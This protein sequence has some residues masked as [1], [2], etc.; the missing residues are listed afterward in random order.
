MDRVRSESSALS[1]G[2][3]EWLEIRRFGCLR[4]GCVAGVAMMAAPTSGWMELPWKCPRRRLT[5]STHLFFA[6]F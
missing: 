3:A 4:C 1:F 2:E 5:T 6:A